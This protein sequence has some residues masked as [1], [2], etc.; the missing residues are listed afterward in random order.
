MIH[1]INLN[2]PDDPYRRKAVCSMKKY[3][4]I[5]AVLVTVMLCVSVLAA[6]FCAAAHTHHD[7]T[8]AGCAV[9]AV[10]EQ[11]DQRLRGAAAA[12]AAVLPVLFFAKY[13]VIPRTA[14]TREASGRTPVTLKV[15]LLN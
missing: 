4:K 1:I 8:G 6:V 15:K 14:G 3:S 10:L 7:C 2:G 12:A 9:C 11:C 5:A 13:A